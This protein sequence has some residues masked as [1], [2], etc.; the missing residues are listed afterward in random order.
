MCFNEQSLSSTRFYS[1]HTQICPLPVFLK[2]CTCLFNV[3][4]MENV[5]LCFDFSSN[6]SAMKIFIH[7]VLS[8][9]SD[10]DKITLGPSFVY[11]LIYEKIFKMLES[12]GRNKN[13]NKNSKIEESKKK[14]KK[15]KKELNNIFFFF[16]KPLI[17][18]KSNTKYLVLQLVQIHKF[19]VGS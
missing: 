8:I 1:K 5:F 14:K 11:F 7:E 3:R 18:V 6:F 2:L 12:G 19:Q 15:K 13:K 16:L 9:N 4:N 17:K 10:N